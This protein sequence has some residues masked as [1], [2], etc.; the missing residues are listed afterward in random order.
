MSTPEPP[1]HYAFPS[2]SPTIPAS[3]FDNPSPSKALFPLSASPSSPP[4]FL[5]QSH[6]PKS[7]PVLSLYL[8]PQISDVLPIPPRLQL[9]NTLSSPNTSLGRHRDSTRYC[10]FRTSTTQSNNS[11]ISR[12][13]VTIS[14]FHDSTTSRLHDSTTSRLHDSTISRFHDSTTQRL[15]D[16][17]IPRLD[18]FVNS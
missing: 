12:L 5:Q 7:S 16:F 6:L 3:L 11:T 8:K 1:S 4:E 9:E 10:I 18:A 2:P 17:T 13:H 14:R 15:H